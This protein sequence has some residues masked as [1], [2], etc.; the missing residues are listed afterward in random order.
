MNDCQRQREMA[1]ARGRE[2][3][4]S[5]AGSTVGTLVDDEQLGVGVEARGRLI[6]VGMRQGPVGFVLD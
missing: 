1:H 2:R 4:Q 5:R 3:R 6:R